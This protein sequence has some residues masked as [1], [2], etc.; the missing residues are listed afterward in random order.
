MNNAIVA[1]IAISFFAL[2]SSL[3]LLFE[4]REIIVIKQLEN[5]F[6]II[7][8]QFLFLGILFYYEIETLSPDSEKNILI[9]LIVPILIIIPFLF[10]TIKVII[11]RVKK[12]Y[13]KKEAKKS[14][15]E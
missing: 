3:L 5:V 9:K 4:R 1:C 11:I 14:I 8:V 13:T 10:M 6:Q 2:L 12:K 15:S 7:S